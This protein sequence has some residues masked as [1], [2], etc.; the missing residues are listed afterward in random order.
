MSPRVAEI[1]RRFI[2]E[3]SK[4]FP[5]GKPASI[6]WQVDLATFKV[7]ETPN[8]PSHYTVEAQERATSTHAPIRRVTFTGGFHPTTLH[9]WL[10]VRT[11]VGIPGT[12]TGNTIPLPAAAPPR[13][14]AEV[15]ALPARTAPMRSAPP[16]VS[17][18]T[19]VSLW[20]HTHARAAQAQTRRIEGKTPSQRPLTAV[21]RRLLDKAACFDERYERDAEVSGVQLGVARQAWRNFSE[22]I[23]SLG[24]GER[25]RERLGLVYAGDEGDLRKM[26]LALSGEPVDARL[27]LLAG[28]APRSVAELSRTLEQFVTEHHAAFGV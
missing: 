17:Y 20:D 2:V 7:T 19:V 5:V 21:E 8:L 24:Q 25:V 3:L 28:E 1:L 11:P 14:P 12:Q 10:D 4:R 27:S 13:K 22:A 9:T 26:A 15:K 23:D 18:D 16:S 6:Y